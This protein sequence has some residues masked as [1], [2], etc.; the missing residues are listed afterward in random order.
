MERK[1]AGTDR[2]TVKRLAD[3]GRYDEQSIHDIVD[4]TFLCHLAITDPE[5]RPVVL[6]TLHARIGNRLYVHGSPASRLLRSARTMEVCCTISVIDGLVLARSAFHH[7][8]N[9][10]SVAVFGRPIEVVDESEK[11]AALD[12]I[13]EHVMTGRAMDCRPASEKELRATTVLSLALDEASAKVRTGWPVDD[14]EDYALPYWAGVV[15]VRQVLGTPLAD[16][17]LSEHA[18]EVPLPAYL[19]SLGD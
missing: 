3:R 11:R 6:P 2:T 16:P 1:Q 18:D 19:A 12:A 10:R 14:D 5:G 4:A 7:S 15:P 17:R 8:V 9:Y 13:V